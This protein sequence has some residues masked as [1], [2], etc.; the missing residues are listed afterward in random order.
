MDEIPAINEFSKM[1]WKS[2]SGDDVDLESIVRICS[3]F[4]NKGAKLFIGTDSFAASH[5]ITFATVICVYGRGISSKY[6]FARDY[7]PKNYFRTLPT[8]ITEE[9]RRTVELAEF[10][11]ESYHID[12]DRMELH[13]D[14]SPFQAKKGTSKYADMLKGYV[15]GAGFQCK[16]KPDAWASQTIADKHSK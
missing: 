7:I 2:A 14:I 6:F 15:A 1:E 9:V 5:K 10:L 4:V 3:R 13:L 11:R 12:P 8:R 16:V